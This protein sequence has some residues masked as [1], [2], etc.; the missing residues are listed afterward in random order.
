[1]FTTQ[2]NHYLCG[3]IQFV[4]MKFNSIKVKRF[5]F[6]L[7][8]LI[9][10][11][12]CSTNVKWNNIDFYE[13]KKLEVTTEKPTA[14]EEDEFAALRD[15][16]ERTIDVTVDLQFMKS[17]DE[18][19]ENAS[20]CN[21]INSLLVEMVLKQS[22]ELN[23]EEAIERYIADKKAEF[24]ADEMSGNMYDHLTGVA[25]YGKTNIIT[26]RLLEEMYTGGAHPL[27]VTTIY[28]FDA[29]SGEF[30]SLEQVFP[31]SNHAAI[32][33]MLTKKLIKDLGKQSIEE[34]K[35]DGY[36]DMTD[37]FVSPNFALRTDSVEFYYNTYDIA[38]YACGPS[39]ICLSY[40]NIKPYI[41]VSF[42]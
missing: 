3:Q 8:I 25:E 21:L 14:T 15:T 20:V 6:S 37:M 1:M 9:L 7:L 23:V 33:E 26:Y 30:L 36:L 32:T 28:S 4:T 29:M 10:A 24:Q 11:S 31:S 5:F 12:A 41:S 17:D 35:A 2:K 34:L 39:V 38:P 40:E 22:S 42:E 19:G 18:N 13:V 16:A 27:S